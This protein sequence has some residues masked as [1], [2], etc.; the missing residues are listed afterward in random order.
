MS[1]S[2]ENPNSGVSFASLAD[3]IAP[4]YEA[5]PDAPAEPARRNSVQVA[6][7]TV[8]RALRRSTAI[9]MRSLG[10]DR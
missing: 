2:N 4:R 10:L 1:A 3:L 6:K 9:S 7:D 5:A 8:T